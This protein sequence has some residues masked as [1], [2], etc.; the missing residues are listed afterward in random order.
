LLANRLASTLCLKNL[1]KNLGKARGYP[2]STAACNTFQPS[3]LQISNS[4]RAWAILSSL[5]VALRCCR[6]CYL[7]ALK[8]LCLS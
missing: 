3:L 7:M 5:R 2:S 6:S 1:I 8:I 4:V